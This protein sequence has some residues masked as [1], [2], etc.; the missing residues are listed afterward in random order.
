MKTEK[1]AG[2][3]VSYSHRDWDGELDELDTEHIGKLIGE[4]YVEG[5]VCTTDPLNENITHYG[6]WRIEK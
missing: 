3:K 6:W 5:E 2:K 4:G 1:I